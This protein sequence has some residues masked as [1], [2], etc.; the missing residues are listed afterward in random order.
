[1]ADKYIGSTPAI[2]SSTL[3]P[4]TL[5][6]SI[7][8]RFRF[9]LNLLPPSFSTGF[10]VGDV[11]EQYACLLF[12]GWRRRHAATV[13]GLYEN[14][15][16]K[17]NGSLEVFDARS[18][19][20]H[21]YSGGGDDCP[22]S[23]ISGIPRA[24]G[25]CCR[26]SVAVAAAGGD[27]HC[28][29]L[30]LAPIGRLRLLGLASFSDWFLHVSGDSG[31]GVLYNR[32]HPLVAAMV[33]LQTVVFLLS[34]PAPGPAV[35]GLVRTC[36]FLFD[37]VK[38]LTS[39]SPDAQRVINCLRDDPH[40]ED[41]LQRAVSGILARKPLTQLERLRLV[42]TVLVR[43]YKHHTSLL[44]AGGAVQGIFSVL[45]LTPVVVALGAGVLSVERAAD[46]VE[47]RHERLPALFEEAR[48]KGAGGEGFLLHTLAAESG[49]VGTSPMSFARLVLWCKTRDKHG[50]LL[51]L[52][53]DPTPE[54]A[55]FGFAAASKMLDFPCLPQRLD[56]GDP[57]DAERAA[58]RFDPLA[59]WITTHVDA[60]G[61]G[62]RPGPAFPSV[63]GVPA[64]YAAVLFV[65]WSAAAAAVDAVTRGALAPPSTLAGTYAGLARNPDGTAAVFDVRSLL[66][67]LRGSTRCP[68]A[69]PWGVALSARPPPPPPPATSVTAAAAGGAGAEA[70][71]ARGGAAAGPPELWCGPACKARRAVENLLVAPGSYGVL[72]LCLPGGAAGVSFAAQDKLAREFVHAAGSG[73]AAAPPSCAHV[74][75]AALVALESL[76]RMLA[77]CES[78][79]VACSLLSVARAL[80]ASMRTCARAQPA[81]QSQLN[82]LR[83]H[84]SSVSSSVACG[85]AAVDLVHAALA[86]A[87]AAVPAPA[88]APG[89]VREHRHVHSL[90]VAEAALKRTYAAGHRSALEPDARP[91]TAAHYACAAGAGADPRAAAGAGAGD[92]SSASRGLGGARGGGRGGHSYGGARFSASSSSSFRSGVRVIPRPLDFAAAAA[93]TPSVARFRSSVGVLFCVLVVAPAV[94]DVA[95]AGSSEEA[96]ADA[97]ERVAARA[98]RLP[99]LLAEARGKL[100]GAA[101]GDGGGE[102]FFLHALA[103]D[104]GIVDADPSRAE[105]SAAAFARLAEWCK[106]RDASGALCNLVTPADLAAL[107]VAAGAG[108]GVPAPVP[109]PGPGPVPVHADA[110]R[111]AAGA[112]AVA[113]VP[114]PAAAADSGA[115]APTTRGV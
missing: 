50:N 4:C 61:S 15:V 19:A 95:A 9:K 18:V 90:S 96:L 88:T 115:A 46:Q 53:K 44:D 52:G 43:A 91:L 3:R 66:W 73:G 17:R 57:L 63:E 80:A 70:P 25:P 7:D 45:S 109:A 93:E 29:F 92:R 98:A 8:C 85:A 55:E 33:A 82:R 103:A 35:L 77:D 112:A 34:R 65:G 14:I 20:W 102:G 72:P 64:R 74:L 114:P 62:P 89:P 68:F 41:M 83:E 40:A 49:L 39:R 1:M 31:V 84:S 69:E 2:D 87:L 28:G 58:L 42:V 13:G 113:A 37:S 11:P 51:N 30:S 86:G 75:P 94:A 36:Q 24:G 27:G 104:A 22:Y 101:A 71:A 32:D 108:S 110:A 100:G 5:E 99:A 81:V 10:D 16:R 111:V 23:P 106:A 67:H 6:K 56:A 26:A 47:A 54:L 60:R 97:A 48:G 78:A 21:M 76:A 79:P 105:A 107:G 12:T 38:E 59:A